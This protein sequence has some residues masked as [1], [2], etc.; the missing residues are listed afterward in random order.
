M[1]PDGEINSGIAVSRPTWN[2]LLDFEMRLISG[3]LFEG[4]QS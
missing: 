4:R 3:E 1:N 2:D